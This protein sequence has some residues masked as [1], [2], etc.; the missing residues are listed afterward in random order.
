MVLELYLNYISHKKLTSKVEGKGF[1]L[2]KYPE[3]TMCP[4]TYVRDLEK[5]AEPTFYIPCGDE[6]EWTKLIVCK[7]SCVFNCVMP[8]KL[9]VQSEVRGSV[10][11]R[12]Y[13]E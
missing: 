4:T 7:V 6:V 12:K 13:M 3:R 11:A 5:G 9:R 2:R 1:F 10:H 8:A